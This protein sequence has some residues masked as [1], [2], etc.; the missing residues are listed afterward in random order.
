MLRDGF[1]QLLGKRVGCAALVTTVPAHGTVY[2]HVA[3]ATDNHLL[4]LYQATVELF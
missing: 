1:G 2:L 3:D 4:D